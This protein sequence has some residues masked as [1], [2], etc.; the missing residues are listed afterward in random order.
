MSSL[1]EL[2]NARLATVTGIDAKSTVVT[3]LYTVPPGKRLIPMGVIIRCTTFTD[4]G[5]KSVQAA[6]SFGS[7]SGGSPA[8]SNYVTTASYTITAVQMCIYVSKFS[9]EYLSVAAGGTFKINITTGS[10]AS[11]AE[12]W[13]VSLFGFLV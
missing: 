2:S 4:S 12:T 8:W 7:D 9:L 3:T 1:R 13:A 5:S 11:T 6:A 10:N